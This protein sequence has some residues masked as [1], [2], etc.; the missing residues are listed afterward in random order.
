MQVRTQAFHVPKRGNA[1]TEYE[2][3]YFPEIAPE[4]EVSGFR[5]AVADGASESAFASVWA[6]LLVRGF[7]RRRV[8]HNLAEY[9]RTI[10]TL[11]HL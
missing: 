11:P 5:C 3:A 6:R 10:E 7:G 1:E 8:D 2:D 9:D 4:R